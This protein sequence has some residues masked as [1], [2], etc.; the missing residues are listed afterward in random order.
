[1]LQQ[2]CNAVLRLKANLK[3]SLIAYTY[4]PALG[5]DPLLNVL[6]FEF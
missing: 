5:I 6:F 2:C 4:F 3:N 1:M